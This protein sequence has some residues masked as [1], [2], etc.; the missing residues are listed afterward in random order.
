MVPGG[1]FREYYW[2]SYFTMLGLAGGR[3]GQVEDMVANFAAEVRR[4]EPLLPTATTYYLNRSA[5]P[6]SPLW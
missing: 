3:L 2:D 6:S 5:A 1:R 4:L